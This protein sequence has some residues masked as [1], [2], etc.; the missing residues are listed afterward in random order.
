MQFRISQAPEMVLSC[1]EVDFKWFPTLDTCVSMSSS[2]PSCPNPTDNSLDLKLG[3][4]HL[5]KEN[6][7][8]TLPKKVKLKTS[9]GGTMA[10]IKVDVAWKLSEKGGMTFPS[11]WVSKGTYPWIQLDLGSEDVAI[12]GLDVHFRYTHHYGAFS[13]IKVTIGNDDPLA[14]II[15]PSGHNSC[16]YVSHYVSSNSLGKVLKLMCK[17]RYYGRYITIQKWSLISKLTKVSGIGVRLG[18]EG[19]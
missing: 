16:M 11:T 17:Q 7:L 1:S 18:S 14:G 3:Y 13:G 6:F 5:L 8:K 9:N 2:T 10:K 12:I 19:T 4:V 15:S